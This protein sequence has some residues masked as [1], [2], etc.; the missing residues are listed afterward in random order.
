MS[1]SCRLSPAVTVVSQR[2]KQSLT[3][4][5]GEKKCKGAGTLKAPPLEP[6]LDIDIVRMCSGSNHM[7]GPS[8]FLAVLMQLGMMP[9]TSGT[10]SLRVLV[11]QHYCPA[12]RPR[13]KYIRTAFSTDSC[14][15]NGLVRPSISQTS[16]SLHAAL[17]V[18]GY[19][20]RIC[21]TND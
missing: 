4:T 1:E 20:R 8:T 2:I 12:A 19:L 11:N 5:L 15:F 6:S 10:S 7:P 16:L 17:A 18:L 13:A 14:G 9:D 3:L 21:F